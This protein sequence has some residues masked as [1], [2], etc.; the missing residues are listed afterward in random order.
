MIDICN[1]PCCLPQ[2]FIAHLHLLLQSLCAHFSL[3][4]HA[5]SHSHA[6]S[7]TCAVLL[8]QLLVILRILLAVATC[9][10]HH[11]VPSCTF[12]DPHCA[13]PVLQH[14]PLLPLQ[15]SSNHSPAC[16]PGT[17]KFLVGFSIDLDG[18]SG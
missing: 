3:A 13:S 8:S 11:F 4:T 6:L 5:P 15:S 16:W 10:M 17:C 9:L 2:K 12:S 18:E 7:P 1:I 14:T